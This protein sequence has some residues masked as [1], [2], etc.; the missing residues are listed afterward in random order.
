MGS[1]IGFESTCDDTGV[2]IVDKDG[3]I[4]SNEIDSQTRMHLWNGGIIPMVAKDL[5]VQAI[6]HV[7]NKAF[8]MSKL[9]S[10]RDGIDAIAVANRPGLTH[11]IQVGL[12]YAKT[13]AKKYTKPLIPIHHMQAHALM[14]LLMHRHIRFPFMTLLI[15]GGHSLIAIAKRF[16]EFHILG[17][18]LDDAPGDVLDKL[19]RRFKLKNLGPPFDNMSGGASIE[20]LA[21][22]GD[23]FRYFNSQTVVPKFKYTTCDFS[24]SGYRSAYESLAPMVDGLWLSGERDRLMRELSD[25]CASFQRVY[26]IQFIKRLH[27]SLTYFRMH[28]RYG[29]EDAFSDR[30][31]SEHLGFGLHDIDF[32]GGTEKLD[33]VI[34]GGVAA[35]KYFVDSI[36]KICDETQQL[37][38]SVYSPSKGLANDNGL[39]IAWNG[40]LHYRNHQQNPG[41][42]ILVNDSDTFNSIDA[43]HQCP[44][45]LDL[46]DDIRARGFSMKK[47]KHPELK[48]NVA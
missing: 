45:G 37:D 14:P 32:Q 23:R 28:W 31:R 25:I 22:G 1:I 48:I 21:Q 4:L 3:N 47:L 43:H 34:S 26:L 27:R 39:M 33:L 17:Q 40:L 5:H 19:A 15:S 11:S 30:N 35:N 13:L 46:R 18:T 8:R 24:F 16:D 12:N 2:A 44:M 10:F 29:N 6:D 20:M 38:M 42:S 36:R 7:A 41:E 9:N